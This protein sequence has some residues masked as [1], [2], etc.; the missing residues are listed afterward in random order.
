MSGDFDTQESNE[1]PSFDQYGGNTSSNSS[2]NKQVTS[3]DLN[4]EA[5]SQE[6][7]ID[8]CVEDD[9]KFEEGSSSKNRKGRVRQYVRSKMPRLRWT[10]E[11]HHAFVNAIERLGG[12]E[13]A[14]PKSV[15][16]L[17]NVRGLSIAH[18]K[19][20][21][22]MYRSKKLDDSGQVLSQR[23]TQTMQGRPHIYSNLYSSRGTPFQ[24]LKL[25]NGGIVLPS[26]LQEG[27]DHCRSH[28]H[29]SGF[30]PTRGI[31]HFL[32]RHQIWLSNQIQGSSPMRRDFGDGNKMMKDILNHMPE[33]PFDANKFHGTMR[34]NQLLEEKKWPHDQ[35]KDKWLPIITSSSTSDPFGLSQC[36]Q[37]Y[38]ERARM[39]HSQSPFN[40]ST[41]LLNSQS[42]AAFLLELKQDKGWK[43]KERKADLKLSLSQNEDVDEENNHQRSTPE[44]NTMLSL[45]LKETETNLE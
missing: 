33:K 21:L 1:E 40:D 2:M 14:T 37:Y 10:P 16:H 38:R 13:K 27:D 23:A 35:R 17:M 8:L 31:H 25:A 6:D 32:S 36:Q 24:H 3:F 15:L 43:D 5:S 22:Q 28:L 42:K 30:R 44:I 18:V 26:N 12:Q 20:H 19:S 41:P 45:S 11:L 34:S 4:E 29:D 7:N 9:Q 39:L